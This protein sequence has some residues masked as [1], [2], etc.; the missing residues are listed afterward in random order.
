VQEG[1]ASDQPPQFV[2]DLV[3]H[4]DLGARTGHGL[5]DWTRR[6]AGDVLAARDR[7]IAARLR[8]ARLRDARSQLP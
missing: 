4:G 8:D 7:F 6:N 3:A 5:Y 1:V 2:R